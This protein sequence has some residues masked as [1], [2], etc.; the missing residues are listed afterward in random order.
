MPNLNFA[1][2]FTKISVMPNLDFAE[3][4]TNIQNIRNQRF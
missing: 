4:F 3:D 2:D 1:E